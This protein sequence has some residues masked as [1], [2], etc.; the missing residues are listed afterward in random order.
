VELTESEVADAQSVP[1]AE[2]KFEQIIIVNTII[3][4]L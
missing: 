4:K 3:P 2:E 1:W